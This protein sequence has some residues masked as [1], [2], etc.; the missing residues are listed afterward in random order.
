MKIRP[1]S[2][3]ENKEWT[4]QN[5]EVYVVARLDKSMSTIE[6]AYVLRQSFREKLH[7]E[8]YEQGNCIYRGTK[9]IEPYE[10]SVFMEEW[11]AK[12]T[13]SKD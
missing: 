5:N 3:M 11:A 6:K 1:A 13:K 4:L 7:L 2:K 10:L 12:N 9:I 8:K